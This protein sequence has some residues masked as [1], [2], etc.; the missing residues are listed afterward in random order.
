MERNTCSFG[1]SKI[2]RTL[3][4]GMQRRKKKEEERKNRA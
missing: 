3:Y 2:K 4:L 1:R